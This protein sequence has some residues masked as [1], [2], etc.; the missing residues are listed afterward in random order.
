MKCMCVAWEVHPSN[1]SPEAAAQAAEG[2]EA[3]GVAHWSSLPAGLQGPDSKHAV[4]AEW[5]GLQG[6]AK[7]LLGGSPSL[8]SLKPKTGSD[9]FLPS[10]TSSPR[11][12]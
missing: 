5:S 8:T 10:T 4:G 6:R 3:R 7:G 2:A 11:N 9:F 12:S 1:P